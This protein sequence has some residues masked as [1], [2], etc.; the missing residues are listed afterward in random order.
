MAVRFSDL[1][2]EMLEANRLGV[3]FSRHLAGGGLTLITRLDA[4][5]FRLIGG[6]LRHFFAV[7]DALDGIFC[8]E[9][10]KELVDFG[11]KRWL[12]E[13]GQV[14]AVDIIDILLAHVNVFRQLRLVAL[15]DFKHGL[16]SKLLGENTD[17]SL[18][19]AALLLLALSLSILT[20]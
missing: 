2:L 7:H 17:G 12:A 5:E 18:G 13:E 16:D 1:V 11:F 8:L 19:C 14:V 6:A 15:A 4:H 10:V 3:V 20:L 9:A